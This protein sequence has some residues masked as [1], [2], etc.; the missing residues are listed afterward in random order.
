MVSA[1]SQPGPWRVWLLAARPATLSAAV[2]PVVVGTAAAAAHG[3]FQLPVFVATFLVA[4]LIQIGTNI[5]NDYF[6]YFK[7][8]DTEARLGPPRV[9]QSGL[10]APDTVRSG[11][12][13]TF[14]LAALIGLY[15]VAAGG[16]P[17]LIIGVVCILA[18]VLYTGGP[19]PYG[20]HGL[21]DIICF[22]CFGVL[23]VVGTAYLQMGAV[24][25]NAL[26]ASVPVGLMVT[27]ILVVNNLR[28]LDT[29]RATGK[30]TLAVLLGRSGTR[31]E[32]VLL[33]T[34]AY[35]VPLGRWF[36]GSGSAWSLLPWLS[37]P[38][39]VLLVRAVFRDS[40]RALNAAL[41]RTSQLHLY[42][43]LLFAASLL[44]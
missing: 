37:L 27:A 5:A 16:P 3:A 17:I 41:K 24:T 29:D 28:D 33:L 7:G 40:G 42:F 43:G 22:A 31:V 10:L 30:R 36:L 19:W 6:D 15:L 39:G 9:T 21:G 25:A 2:V 13:V 34:G 23:A 32:Y 11:M 18:G 44:L 4:V 20:Y 35:L 26:V 1:L 14:G 8:A 38:L 12:I